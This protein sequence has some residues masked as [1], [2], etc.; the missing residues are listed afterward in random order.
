VVFSSI[1][2]TGGRGAD[3]FHA[4]AG[5]GLDLVTD[6]NAAEGDRVELDAGAPYTVTQQGADT[7]IGLSGARVVLKN[8]KAEDLG[9]GGIYSR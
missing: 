6:F 2:L 4:S 8:V 1:T 5:A 7:V 9:K 3:T